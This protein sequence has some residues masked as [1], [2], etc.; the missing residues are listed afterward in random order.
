[1]ERDAEQVAKALNHWKKHIDP[2]I[3]P[4]ALEL[5]REY[6]ARFSDLPEGVKAHALPRV[7]PGCA[8][9]YAALENG[10][11]REEAVHEAAEAMYQTIV[12]PSL[13]RMRRILKI[14]G[15][16]RLLP[17][18]A[19]KTISKSY[20]EAAGFQ[21]DML[22]TDSRNVEF[23]VRKCPY[24]ELCG[25]LGCPEMTDVFCTSDDISFSRLHP[26]LVFQRSSTIGRGQALCDFRF[27]LK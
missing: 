11:T 23:D 27:H 24:A 21:V 13:R 5:G 20:N 3:F 12:Y 17:R 26:R 15:L 19:S 1:M 18:L 22:R 6:A 9:F 7:F 14:P 16:C 8:V 10:R 4:R 2:Q 25:L